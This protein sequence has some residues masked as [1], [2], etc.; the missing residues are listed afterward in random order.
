MKQLLDS[1]NIHSRLIILFLLLILTYSGLIHCFA[2]AYL[3]CNFS[4]HPCDGLLGC[5]VDTFFFPS[6]E[7]IIN[8]FFKEI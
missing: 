3:L 5:I 7:L 8:I 6:K 2:L 4:F 1:I